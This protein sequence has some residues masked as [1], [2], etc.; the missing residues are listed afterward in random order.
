MNKRT[1]REAHLL[2]GGELYHERGRSGVILTFATKHAM[3][4]SV[5]VFIDCVGGVHDSFNE[6]GI[7]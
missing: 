7:I 5:C 6:L 4:A 1:I 3:R 2:K